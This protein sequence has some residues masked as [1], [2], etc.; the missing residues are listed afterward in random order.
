MMGT[1]QRPVAGARIEAEHFHV[2]LVVADIDLDLLIGPGNKERRSVAGDGDLAAQRQA[3][4]HTDQRLFGNADVD[5][6]L[7]EALHEGADLGGGRRITDHRHQVQSFVD[8]RDKGV[9]HHAGKMLTRHDSTPPV[10][11]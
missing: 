6:A 8:G 4:S 5:H 1:R 2:G 11:R 10:L 9:H 3:R 7:R